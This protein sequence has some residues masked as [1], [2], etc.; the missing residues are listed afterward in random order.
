M[1]SRSLKF[2]KFLNAKCDYVIARMLQN[3]KLGEGF[4]ELNVTKQM[5]PRNG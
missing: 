5:R 4:C 1:W 2:H 3:L